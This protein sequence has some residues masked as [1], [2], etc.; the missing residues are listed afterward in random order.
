MKDMDRFWKTLLIVLCVLD[1]LV[2]PLFIQHPLNVLFRDLLNPDG[3]MILQPRFR[4]MSTIVCLLITYASSLL[5][6]I[7]SKPPKWLYVL[8][9]ICTILW[10]LYIA[11]TLWIVVTD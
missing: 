9:A 6:L 5:F 10:T 1:A 7:L 8:H 2:L 11:F 3:W 4:I